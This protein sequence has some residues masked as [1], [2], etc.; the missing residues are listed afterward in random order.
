MDLEN[1]Y[2]YGKIS[3]NFLL[4]PTNKQPTVVTL[5][6]TVMYIVILYIIQLIMYST[7]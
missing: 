7:M 3:N 5:Y 4:D 2:F 6:C 1:F